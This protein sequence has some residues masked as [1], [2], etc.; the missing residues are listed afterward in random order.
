VGRGR[1]SGRM[2]DAGYGMRDARCSMR[3]TL[4]GVRGVGIPK[5]TPPVDNAEHLGWI[6]ELLD[7][8]KKAKAQE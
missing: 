8:L 5:P 4:R 1:A 6:V 3:A 7:W 2:L